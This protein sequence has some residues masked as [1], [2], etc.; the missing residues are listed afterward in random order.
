MPLRLSALAFVE[1]QSRIALICFE[2]ERR[3]LTCDP[4]ALTDQQKAAAN[5][6]HIYQPQDKLT[7][8]A[9]VYYKSGNVSERSFRR[10]LDRALAVRVEV[11]FKPRRGGQQ[12][13][14]DVREEIEKLDSAVVNRIESSNRLRSRLSIV[15]DFDEENECYRHIRTLII[16][17]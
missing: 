7:Y 14:K 12:G 10:S 4:D 17:S 15:E 8:P 3:G 9:I 6:F 1:E 11:R 5:V 2:R 13:R 16:L